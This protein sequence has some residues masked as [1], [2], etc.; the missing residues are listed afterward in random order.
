MLA[1][2]TP[3]HDV[4]A[5]IDNFRHQTYP[6]KELIIVNN[7]RSQLAASELN[8]QASRDVFM[9]DTPFYLSTG[10]ARNYGIAAANGQILAQWDPEFWFAPNR[11]E[12]QVATMAQDEAQ[13]VVLAET[14]SYSFGSGRA[15]YWTNDKRAVLNTMLF[16]RPTGIDYPNIE[17]QEELGMLER[18]QKAGGRV[19]SMPSPELACRLSLTDGERV[20]TPVNSGLTSPH[21]KVLKSILRGYRASSPRSAGGRVR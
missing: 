8:I 5:A 3:L 1:G 13:V 21:L 17:K 20:L 12:A 10:I 19:I 7:A 18:L 15:S 11:I 4:L 14:M 2:R 16:V 6:Y 9:V